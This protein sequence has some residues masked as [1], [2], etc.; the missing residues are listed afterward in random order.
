MSLADPPSPLENIECEA[1]LIGAI[2]YDNRTVD[3]AADKLTQDDFADPLLGS[4][5]SV[6]VS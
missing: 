5:F 6:C 4:I 3:Y 1:A 2:M